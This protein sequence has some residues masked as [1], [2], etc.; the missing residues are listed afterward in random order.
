MLISIKMRVGGVTKYELVRI[1]GKPT[2]KQMNNTSIECMLCYMHS[3]LIN[4]C[5]TE[6]V[7]SAGLL[8]QAKSMLIA[9]AMER[10]AAEYELC[11]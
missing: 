11:E 8:A 4:C 9:S 6:K 3:S 10:I 2:T 1:F 5:K 7:D